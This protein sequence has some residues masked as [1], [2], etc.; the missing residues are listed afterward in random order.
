[1]ARANGFSFSNFKANFTNPAHANQFRVDIFAPNSI[2]SLIPNVREV[3]NVLSFRA[4]ASAIPSLDLNP[5]EVAFAGR[6]CKIPGDRD[7]ADWTTTIYLEN[8][9]PER[10]FFE[11]WQDAISGVRDADRAPTAETSYTADAQ[12]HLMNQNAEIQATYNIEDIWPQ[13]IGEIALDFDNPE[14]LTTDVTFA[15]N[16]I[17]TIG[18]REEL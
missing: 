13:S 9:L 5:I 8:G 16:N 6:K 1:M 17:S 10:K 15:I 2:R 7:L 3:E 14:I 4:K 12:V 18:I 11:A